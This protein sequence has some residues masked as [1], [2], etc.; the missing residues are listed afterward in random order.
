MK[1]F[2]KDMAF[3][4]WPKLGRI[5][6]LTPNRVKAASSEIKLGLMIPLK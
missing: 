1:T 2:L 6:L 4:K 3:T 5:N